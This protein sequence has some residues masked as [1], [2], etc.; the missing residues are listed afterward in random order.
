MFENE[1]CVSLVSKMLDGETKYAQTQ[2]EKDEKSHK[3]LVFRQKN[4]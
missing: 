1:K 4:W 2:K 3:C